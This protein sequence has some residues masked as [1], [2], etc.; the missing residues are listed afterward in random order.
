[1]AEKIKQQ[2]QPAEEG[3]QS[4]EKVAQ[5]HGAKRQKKVIEK[6]DEDEE[7]QRGGCACPKK[8]I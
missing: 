1:M 4:E 8:G 6:E 7:G 3:K 5:E 2:R